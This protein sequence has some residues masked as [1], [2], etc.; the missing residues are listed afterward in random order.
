MDGEKELWQHEDL[1]LNFVMISKGGEVLGALHDEVE[2]LLWMVQRMQL[3]TFLDLGFISVSNGEGKE[4]QQ[5]GFKT[6]DTGKVQTPHV[7]LRS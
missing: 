3:Y 7:Y 2:L 5:I 4:I 1:D 6:D